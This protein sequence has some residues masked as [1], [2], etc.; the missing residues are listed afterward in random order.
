MAR[1]QSLK[2][3]Y[4][5][6]KPTNY[7]ISSISDFVIPLRYRFF[8]DDIDKAEKGGQIPAHLRRNPPY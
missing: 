2:P 8:V 1:L 3:K 7:L 4:L 6:A 5:K